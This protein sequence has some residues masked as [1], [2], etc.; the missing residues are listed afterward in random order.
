MSLNPEDLHVVSFETE[1]DPGTDIGTDTGTDTGADTGTTF[2]PPSANPPMCDSP[3][4]AI[5]IDR[6]C[7]HHGC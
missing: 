3:F 2:G 5:T 4:C 1:P 7:P 6:T